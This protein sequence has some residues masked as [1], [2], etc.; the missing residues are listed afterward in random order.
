M[1]LSG[2]RHQGEV[3]F[4]T[5]RDLA[6]RRRVTDAVPPDSQRTNRAMIDAELLEI[7]VC[8][9]TKQPVHEA[10]DELVSRVNAAIEAGD[11]ENQGG[12]RV[13][14]TIDGGLVREDGTV[15]YPV[16]DGIPIM[17]IDEAIVLDELP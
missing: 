17:L 7:L 11:V 3:D 16:R 4:P 6:S 12:D 15:L 13:R 5:G 8:P 2:R 1:G 10:D 14:E 9:D